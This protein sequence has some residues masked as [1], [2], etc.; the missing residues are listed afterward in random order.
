MDIDKGTILKA[1]KDEDYRASLPDDVRNAI[2]ARPTGEDGS[3]LS[4]EQLEQAAGG[5]TPACIASFAASVAIE[6][7]WD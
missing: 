3:A 2:P 7:A 1:W 5:T 6:E 4:D